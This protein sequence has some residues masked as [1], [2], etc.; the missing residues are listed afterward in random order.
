MQIG[1]SLEAEPGIMHVQNL[2]DAEGIMTIVA[3]VRNTQNGEV[4][5]LQ[6]TQR[7]HKRD[8]LTDDHSTDNPALLEDSHLEPDWWC[9][10]KTTN[11]MVEV[12]CNIPLVYDTDAGLIVSLDDEE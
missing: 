12:A 6:V 2:G 8:A 4:G 1:K 9:D 7:F 5:H 11:G 3:I 10:L